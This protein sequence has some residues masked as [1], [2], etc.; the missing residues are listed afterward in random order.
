MSSEHMI[1]LVGV[2]DSLQDRSKIIQCFQ[3][4]VWRCV[5]PPGALEYDHYFSQ[6]ADSDDVYIEIERSAHC[7]RVLGYIDAHSES[8]AL[9]LMF[10]DP[11]LG[12]EIT[13]IQALP[14]FF[15]EP[16]VTHV[17]CC[18]KDRMNW[19]DFQ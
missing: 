18:E 13:L 17:I 4:Q 11:L 15:D 9:N 8:S 1:T 12:L 7:V 19:R 16:D 5:H 3:V 14:T 6:Y 2:G 10:S